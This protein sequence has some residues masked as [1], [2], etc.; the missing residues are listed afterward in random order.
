MYLVFMSR[1]LKSAG[2]ICSFNFSWI[3]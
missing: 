1:L 3:I 2:E